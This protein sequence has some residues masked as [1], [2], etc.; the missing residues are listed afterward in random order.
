[1]WKILSYLQKKL[2]WAIPVAMIIGLASGV[3]MNTSF[4][5]NA[6]MP[7]TFLM[8]YPM[9]VNLQIKKIFSGGDSKVQIFTQFINFLIIPFVA[10]LIGRLFF[11]N[12]PFL[13]LGIL[14]AALLPTSGMTIS[15][16]GFAKGNINAAVKMT[17]VGLLIGSIATPIYI[18]VLMGESVSVPLIS[19]FQQILL[20]VFIPMIAGQMTQFIIIKKV[21]EQ[22]YNKDIKQKFPLISTLGVL[23]I[24]MVAMSLKAKTILADPLMLINIII[25]LVLMYFL[26]FIIST[27]IA[28]R[29]FN[30][31]DGIA[32]IYGSVMRNLSIAL[33]IAMTAFG[34]RGSDIALV[35]AIAY[36]IQVQSAA[37]YVTFSGKIFSWNKGENKV[38][39]EAESN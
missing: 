18:Q 4:L 34:P 23:G 15:W 21:G 6:I 29:F 9:M 24:V 8:V 10:Y 12:A 39:T 26:N 16:T 27:M 33:A 5:K 7:L 11:T 2:I 30:R 14:L 22:K 35:I 38:A 32:L 1:M 17:V 13:A 20:V 36:I 28:R 19:I 3:I 25:P 31:E 37:L